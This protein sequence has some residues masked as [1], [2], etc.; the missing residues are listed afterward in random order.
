MHLLGY[1]AAVGSVVVNQATQKYDVLEPESN[2]RRREGGMIINSAIRKFTPA[3]LTNPGS[4]LGIPC[5][6]KKTLLVVE[7]C[8]A[9]IFAVFESCVY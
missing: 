5:E 9:K 1:Y 4:R 6:I 8:T 7:K 2:H 3:V